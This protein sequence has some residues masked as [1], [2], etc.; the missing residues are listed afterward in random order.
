LVESIVQ[1][2]WIQRADYNVKHNKLSMVLHACNS[3]TWEAET[4]VL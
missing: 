3:S 4:G 1:K 2:L